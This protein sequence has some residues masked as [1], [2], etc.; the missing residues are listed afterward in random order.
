[1]GVHAGVAAPNLRAGVC[2]AALG[3]TSAEPRDWTDEEIALVEETAERTWAFV[4]RVRAEARLRGSEERF[5]T[6][7]DAVPA[8]IWHNDA[9][10]TCLG[11]VGVSVNVDGRD[12]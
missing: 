4:E 10:G 5:R 11:H 1:V 3:I 6:V 7:A 9:D 2:V 8:L 12:G